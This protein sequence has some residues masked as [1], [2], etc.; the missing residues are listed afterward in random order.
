MSFWSIAALRTILATETDADSP[1]SEELLYQIR[2][3]IEAILMLAFAV[4]PASTCTADPSNDALGYFYDT[5]PAWTDDLH[6]G[7]TLLIKS[8]AAIGNMYTIDNTDD[9]NDRLDCTGD[10]LYADGVRSGD[11]YLILYDIKNNQDGHD[12][13][14]V[15]SREAVLAKGRVPVY[16]RKATEVEV[17]AT[18]VAG[19]PLLVDYFRIYVPAAA[20]KL[21]LAARLHNDG[22]EYAYLM[23]NEATAGNGGVVQTNNNIYAWIEETTGLD[24]SALSN[25]WVTINVYQWTSNAL[26]TAYMMGY[27]IIWGP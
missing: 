27:T 11:S 4:A 15:N 13:D 16:I 1:G 3:N 19:A 23:L 21:Y 24:L 9:A 22:T 7:R 6:N 14:G 18:E 2:E 5:V 17:E 10:N 25:Q 26:N 12:H 20:N 8:G